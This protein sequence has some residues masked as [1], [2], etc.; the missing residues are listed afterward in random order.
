MMEEKKIVLQ[1]SLLKVHFLFFSMR[2]TFGFDD[3]VRRGK[4][5]WKSNDRY[6]FFSAWNGRDDANQCFNNF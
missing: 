6:S 4:M 2:F 1:Q 5:I 3:G